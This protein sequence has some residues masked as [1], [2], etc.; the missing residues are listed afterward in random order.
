MSKRAMRLAEKYR[1][2]K[3]E[4]FIGLPKIK[5]VVLNFL[6]NPYAAAFLFIGEPGVGKTPFAMAMAEALHSKPLHLASETC[7]YD[8]L[9]KLLREL[10]CH[11]TLWNG[12]HAKFHFVLIDEID[13]TTQTAQRR[14]LAKLDASELVDNTVFVFTTNTVKSLEKRFTSRCIEL[15]FSLWGAG[16]EVADFLGQVWKAEG[17]TG[18]EPDWSDVISTCSSNRIPNVRA[19]L[20]RVERELLARGVNVVL[21]DQVRINEVTNLPEIAPELRPNCP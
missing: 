17:G 15:E 9:D 19:C 13:S 11:P 10:E 16:Q 3:V 20:Q 4:D 21:A 5:A 7:N 14:L 2:R 8:N 18:K 12:E 1:P 6:K